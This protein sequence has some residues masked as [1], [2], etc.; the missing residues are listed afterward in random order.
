MTGV[1]I[2]ASQWSF[3]GEPGLVRLGEDRKVRRD[4]VLNFTRRAGTDLQSGSF[5]TWKGDL[6]IPA[7]GTYGIYLQVL[8][9][10]ATLR[11][12]GKMIS[13]TT[14]LIGARHGDIVQPAQDNLL[15]TTDGL[16]NVRRDVWLSAG[17]HLIMLSTSDDTSHEPVQ[18]RLAWVTPQA[19]RRDFQQAVALGAHARKVV[20]FAWARGTPVFGLPDRQN[21][22]IDA[23]S[24][25]NPNTVVVLNTSLPVAMPW[26]SKVKAVLE[27]WWP[28]D[29]GGE[30]TADVLQGRVSP[31]GRLPFTWARRLQDYPATDPQYPERGVSSS[32]K[33]VYSEG[34]F[35]GYRWFDK[36]R[37]SPL[38]PFGYGLSYTNFAYSDLNV[39]RAPDGGLR[40]AFKIR[41]V[42]R[43][44]SDDV[45]QVYLGAPMQPPR[46][47][48]F[49]V[50]A[51]AGFDRVYLRPGVTSIVTIHVPSRSLQYWSAQANSWATVL[52]TRYIY[53]G[54]SAG[55]LC[56]K[57]LVRLD[58]LALPIGRRPA[59]GRTPSVR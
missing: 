57:R 30:A 59:Q 44:P 17:N 52:G 4:A 18:V 49:A 11:I 54:Q 53:V 56:V 43:V 19:R 58:R 51:L 36:Q 40:V 14:S 37:I 55:N 23:I 45:P 6:K 15:P 33:V 41:N 31:A 34:I 50:R 28:G 27:M 48:Q 20:I 26:L 22:L 1:S 39:S 10:N 13:H 8:G 35:V 21:A 12:D 25:V 3:Q 7:A 5:P 29:E 42:G 47:A 38:Y 24:A 9:A 16:D 46:G 32:G 2:P